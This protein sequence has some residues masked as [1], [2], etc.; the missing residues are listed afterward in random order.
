MSSL[1]GLD[2]LMFYRCPKLGG[3]VPF[4]YCRT[5]KDGLF[6]ERI[7]LCW[8]TMCDIVGFLQKHF[9]KETMAKCFQSSGGRIDILTKALKDSTTR[10]K[11]KT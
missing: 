5:V 10:K 7:I 4:K 11:T 3:E 2:H 6:C 8:E 9:D 1:T